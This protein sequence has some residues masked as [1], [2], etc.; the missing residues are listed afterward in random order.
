ME[1]KKPPDLFED[2]VR[3]AEVHYI[4]DLPQY[5]P[6]RCIFELL[7]SLDETGYPLP[8]WET[9]VSYITG[10]PYEFGTFSDLKQTLMALC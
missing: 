4:S 10:R 9:V 6:R 3:M 2:L 1:R 5:T 7:L 8:M